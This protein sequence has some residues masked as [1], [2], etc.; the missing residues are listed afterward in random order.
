MSILLILY[1]T[2]G[3][4]KSFIPFFSTQSLLY[5]ILQFYILPNIRQFQ[6]FLCL[7]SLLNSRL[8]LK[9]FWTLFLNF[10]KDTNTHPRFENK[11]GQHILDIAA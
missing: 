7:S 3:Y 1:Y 10:L 4:S 5:I 8:P 2:S 11:K 9:T 6:F